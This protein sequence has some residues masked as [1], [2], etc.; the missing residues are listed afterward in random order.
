MPRTLVLFALLSSTLAS[1]RIHD[2]CHTDDAGAR[3]FAVAYTGG[4]LDAKSDSM[5][6]GKKLYSMPAL[7]YEQA[8]GQVCKVIDEH[9]ELWERSSREAVTFAVDALWKRKD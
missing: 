1:A 4:I 8:F 5:V 9:P 7:S 2:D 3:V 6:D